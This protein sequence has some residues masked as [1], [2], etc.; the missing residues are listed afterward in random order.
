MQD[1][2]RGM[3]LYARALDECADR[4]LTPSIKGFTDPRSWEELIVQL[5]RGDFLHDILVPMTVNAIRSV[6]PDAPPE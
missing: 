1:Y 4:F 3:D 5:K 6:P 2:R